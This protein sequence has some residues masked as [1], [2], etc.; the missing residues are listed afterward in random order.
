MMTVQVATTMGVKT[1]QAETQEQLRIEAAKAVNACD[2]FWEELG[3]RER[4]AQEALRKC[5]A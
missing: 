3:A 4:E 1:V 5:S 2:R